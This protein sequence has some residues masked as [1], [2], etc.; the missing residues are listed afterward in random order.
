MRSPAQHEPNTLTQMLRDHVSFN[1]QTFYFFTVA[2]LRKLWSTPGSAVHATLRMWLY[3]M[4]RK[5]VLQYLSQQER[6]YV[7]TH[8]FHL[9]TASNPLSINDVL[10]VGR[11]ITLPPHLLNATP[12]DQLPAS[13]EA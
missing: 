2:S 13:T 3:E 6:F 10:S 8:T 12:T 5:G 11:I 9:F 7:K 4:N 1:E